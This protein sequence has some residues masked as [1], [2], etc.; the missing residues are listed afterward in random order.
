MTELNDYYD[1]IYLSPHFDDA[2][3]SCGGQVFRHTAVGETVLVVTVTAAD[4]PEANLS[5][6]ARSIHERWAASLDKTPAGMVAQRRAEDR[7]AFA[8]LRADVLHLPFLDCIY[9]V[10]VDGAPLYPGPVD[11]FMA[12]N[13]ADHH[14]IDELAKA[15]AALPE[16]GTVYLPLG[17]G[18]HVDHKITRIAGEMTFSEAYYYEDYPYTAIPGALEIALPPAERPEWI[19]T[20]HWLTESSMMAKLESIAQYHTQLSSFF[21]DGDDMA[22]KLRAEGSRVL[23]AAQGDGDIPPNWAIGAEYI[24]HHRRT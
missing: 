19:A 14:T 15:F 8:V 12:M 3:L 4:P 2:A 5:E 16:A 24:W 17:V 6:T 21:I 20:A 9:R 13:P 22:E 1:H 11:M 18:S 10:G 23:A 7:A